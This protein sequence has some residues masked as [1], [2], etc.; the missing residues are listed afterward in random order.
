MPLYGDDDDDNDDD[1]DDYD[2]EDD[3]D[4][5]IGQ[6]SHRSV[7]CTSLT[8]HCLFTREWNRTEWNDCILFHFWYHFLSFH[9]L[10]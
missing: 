4:D 2:D 5:D 10:E 9:F 3:D 7:F 1:D 8:P 6:K